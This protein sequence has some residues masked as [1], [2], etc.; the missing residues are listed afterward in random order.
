M[1]YPTDTEME[2]MADEML[3]ARIE[4]EPADGQETANIKRMTA[5]P[6]PYAPTREKAE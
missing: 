5:C 6:R 3:E 2:E 1:N 4:G